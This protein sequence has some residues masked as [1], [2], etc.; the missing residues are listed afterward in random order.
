M[1]SWAIGRS[2]DLKTLVRFNMTAAG[3]LIAKAKRQYAAD[4]GSAEATGDARDRR[5]SSPA[6]SGG[7]LPNASRLKCSVGDA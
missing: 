1:P 7:P 3:V 6:S 4:R 5:P 2:S